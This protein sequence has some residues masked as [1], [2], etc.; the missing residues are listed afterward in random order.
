MTPWLAILA[1]VG[2]LLAAF[3]GLRALVEL[4]W[5]PI[6][7]WPTNEVRRN[8]RAARIVDFRNRRDP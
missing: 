1:V 2:G 6:I 5:P 7:V 4:A 3:Y 8:A